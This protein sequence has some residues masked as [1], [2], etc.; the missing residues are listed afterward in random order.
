MVEQANR[1][2]VLAGLEP[3]RFTTLPND[4]GIVYI[5]GMNEDGTLMQGVFLQRERDGRVE[6][7]TAREGAM[8]F[9]GERERYLQLREGHRTEGPLSGALD[10]RLM[11]YA[12]NEVAPAYRR[13]R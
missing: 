5:D 6:V 12:I 8:Q 10:F 9:A 11:R 13:P 1:S 7:M 3:G 4:G 2:L